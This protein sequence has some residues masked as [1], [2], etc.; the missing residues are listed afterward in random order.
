MS[1]SEEETNLIRDRESETQLLV[2][3]RSAAEAD[4]A[5]AGGANILDIK[6]PSNGSLGMATIETITQTAKQN[7]LRPHQIPLSVALGELVDWD[8]PTKIPSLPAGITF[9]K[10]GLSQCLGKPGWPADWRRCRQA[11]QQQSASKLN[12]V[13]VAYSDAS[14]AASPCLEDIVAAAIETKC[15]GLL[16]DTWTKD[17][18]NLLDGV[19]VVTLT[20]SA[21]EAH[22][23]GL[24]LAIAGKLNPSLLPKLRNIC[25]DIIA[26]RSAACVQSNRTE[27]ID[28]AQI[29]E[30]R[31][32]MRTTFSDRPINRPRPYTA[33][34]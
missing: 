26:I 34:R 31:R 7:Q 1:A 23:A 28:A 8:H 17:G 24:F 21:S 6:E 22:A 29:V 9:A 27:G 5:V 16:I 11:F 25:A 19:D 2:S 14:D 30:F 20:R 10:L 4:L 33:V 15:S 32:L 12:W 18:R 13:A 3:V